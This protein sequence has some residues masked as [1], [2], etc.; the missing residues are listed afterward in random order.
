MNMGLCPTRASRAR[1]PANNNKKKK[2]KNKNKNK[3]NNR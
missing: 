3:N 2:N 1:K